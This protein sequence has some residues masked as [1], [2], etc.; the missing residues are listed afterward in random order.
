MTTTAGDRYRQEAER[1][2]RVAESDPSPETYEAAARMFLTAGSAYGAEANWYA[3]IDDQAHVV[4]RS[5]EAEAA[6]RRACVAIERSAD[7]D[8]HRSVRATE[9]MKARRADA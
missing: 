6:K 5:L 4:D 8:A 2:L 7:A 9:K 1:L 3:S